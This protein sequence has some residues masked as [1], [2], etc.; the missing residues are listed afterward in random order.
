MILQQSVYRDD[1]SIVQSSFH[2][3]QIPSPAAENRGEAGNFFNRWWAIV[4]MGI[5][6]PV[7]SISLFYIFLRRYMAFLLKQRPSDNATSRTPSQRE[8]REGESSTDSNRGI[9]EED[10]AAVPIEPTYRTVT[11]RE[12]LLTSGYPIISERTEVVQYTPTRAPLRM[13]R[14]A[15]DARVLLE[16]LLKRHGTKEDGD[17]VI[18]IEHMDGSPITSGQ[19]GH[20]VHEQCLKQWFI[21][22]QCFTCPVCRVKISSE[23]TQ[24][25][26]KTKVIEHKENLAESSASESEA[27]SPNHILVT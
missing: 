6:L 9:T 18:C 8:D 14:K 12:I 23:A 5:V 22:S 2:E 19:C 20:L 17:C 10:Y 3:A 21:K 24:T 15:R 7:V 4:L 27:L 25:D 16:N 1:Y 26:D 13:V 11:R